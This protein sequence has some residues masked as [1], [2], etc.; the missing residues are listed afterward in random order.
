MLLI[1]STFYVGSPLGPR[2]SGPVA[3]P[4]LFWHGH[5]TAKRG[6]PLYRWL[7]ADIDSLVSVTK[8]SSRTCIIPNCP[9]P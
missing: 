5:G 1:L 4:A 7:T 8:L 2:P 3:A 6:A 9:L